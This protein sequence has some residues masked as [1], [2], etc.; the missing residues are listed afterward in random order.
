MNQIKLSEIKEKL[1]NE[2][3]KKLYRMVIGCNTILEY[4]E[5]EDNLNKE[6]LKKSEC[7]GEIERVAARI[8]EDKYSMG[9]VDCENRF[10]Q[11]GN[12]NLSIDDLN[13]LFFL[14]QNYSIS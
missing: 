7:C 14:F 6:D 11:N 12:N 2:P 4:F 13:D 1:K 10:S 8:L 9:L 3:P 5:N